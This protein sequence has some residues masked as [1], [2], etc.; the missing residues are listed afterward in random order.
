MSISRETRKNILD[1]LSIERVAWSGRLDDVQF[2]SRIF[3]LEDLPS[4]DYRFADAA[5]DISQHRIL[6]PHDWEDDWVFSDKR[7]DL[8]GCPDETFL[9]FVAEMLHPVVR[10]DPDESRELAEQLNDLLRE[11]GYELVVRTRIGDRPVWA[12]QHHSLHSSTALPGVRHAKG[13]FDADEMLRQMTRMEAAIE[14]D[15]ALAIGTA[16]ELVESTCKA[17]LD[18]RGGPAT[19]REDLPRLVRRV[20][21]ELSLL[22]EDA[23]ASR[24]ADTVRRVL[25]SLATLS[26]SIAEL[27]NSYGTGHGRLPGSP[28]LTA[29]HAKLA[30]GAATTLA[31]FLYE[32]H[33]DRSP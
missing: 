8:I 28:Q 20:A 9:L 11:D 30:V 19:G 27:R 3:D 4:Y 16:K 29:R 17:I 25:G 13:T 15:P 5:G 23:A 6:N 21:E 26:G 14:A 1:W 18:A 22:P 31:V 7:F 32:T 33:V 12:G 24:D 2:L 10:P